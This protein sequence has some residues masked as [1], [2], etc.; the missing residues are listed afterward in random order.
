MIK[1]L[2]RLKI[3]SNPIIS[4]SLNDSIESLE[5]QIPQIIKITQ[6]CLENPSI[7]DFL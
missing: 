4:K 5:N 1:Y 7:Y 6:K 3:I 2:I